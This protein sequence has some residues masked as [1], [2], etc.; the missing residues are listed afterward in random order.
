MFIFLYILITLLLLII[1]SMGWFLY[2]KPKCELVNAHNHS[3]SILKQKENVSEEHYELIDNL[4]K[5]KNLDDVFEALFKELSQANELNKRI[6]Q[7]NE[8]ND[9]QYSE[10]TSSL[11]Q[12]S[13]LIIKISHQM[14][15]SLSGLLGFEKFLLETNLTKKQNE[16][17]MLM[18]ESSKELLTLVDNILETAPRLNMNDRKLFLDKIEPVV[19]QKKPKVLIVDDNDI[20]KKLLLKVLERF[21]VSVQHASNGK[22]AVLLRETEDFDMIFMDIEMPIMNGV[23]A[24]MEIRKFEKEKNKTEIPIVALTA[25]TGR[26]HREIYLNAGMNDYMIKPIQIDEVKKRVEKLFAA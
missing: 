23:D 16:Y 3:S 1:V 2:F 13:N 7:A 5:Y 10:L 15:T 8:K 20:N 22:E 19:K 26:A 6:Q 11:S 21:D 17:I 24:S 25:N 18:S 14:R 9:R 12:K 4:S